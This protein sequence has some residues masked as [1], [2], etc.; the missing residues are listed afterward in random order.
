CVASGIDGKLSRS[1]FACIGASFF[2]EVPTDVD[3]RVDPP[4]HD[5]DVCQ[6]VVCRATPARFHAEDLRS[7]DGDSNVLKDAALS[8]EDTAGLYRDCQAMKRRQSK[9]DDGAR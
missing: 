6:I 1:F 2:I 5:S 7:F 4:G 3:V 9:E 8:V